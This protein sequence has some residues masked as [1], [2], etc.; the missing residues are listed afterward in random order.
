MYIYLFV[1]IYLNNSY[2]VVD[3]IFAVDVF[4]YANLIE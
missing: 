2:S 4:H 1:Y 3:A